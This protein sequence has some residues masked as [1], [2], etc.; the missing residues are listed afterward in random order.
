MVAPEVRF[1]TLLDLTGGILFVQMAKLISN[2]ARL[3][4]NAYVKSLGVH[5]SPV[6][7]CNGPYLQ[8]TV[9][10][11]MDWTLDFG[12]CVWENDWC[13]CIELV[14]GHSVICY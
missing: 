14:L 7:Y 5:N 3:V 4:A 1:Q 6:K 13:A 10:S 2:W 11:H 9:S 8:L 12:L